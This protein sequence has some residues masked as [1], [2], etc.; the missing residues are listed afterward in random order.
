MADTDPIWPIA[1]TLVHTR[2]TKTEVAVHRLGG[3]SAVLVLR[4]GEVSDVS[5]HVQHLD[6]I[7]SIHRVLGFAL[8]ALKDR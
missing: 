4:F 3:E 8:D 6:E 1:N 7:D 2:G 5:I